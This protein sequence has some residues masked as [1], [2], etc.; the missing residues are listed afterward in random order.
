VV[1]PLADIHGS[2]EYRRGLVGVAVERA[3]TDAAQRSR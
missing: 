1:Q 3:L 2:S